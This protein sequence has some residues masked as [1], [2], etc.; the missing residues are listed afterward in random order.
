[1][2][3][4]YPAILDA[5]RLDRRITLQVFT[6]T[7]DEYGEVI[8][9]WTDLAEV[10]AEVRPLRG[11]ERVEAAQLAAQVDTRFTIRYR[12]DL[13]PGRHRITYQGRRY[14]IQAVLELGRREALQLE[15]VWA[16]APTGGMQTRAR[17]PV[18]R[19]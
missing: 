2:P 1:M 4:T 17:A 13:A 10:W 11:V 12:D 5:G 15:A 6:S 19:L 9:T 3:T 14:N 18:G 7:T 16:D 8:E